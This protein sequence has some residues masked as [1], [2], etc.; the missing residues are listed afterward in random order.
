MT[1]IKHPGQNFDHMNLL[2]EQESVWIEVIN[3]IDQA[4]V[5]LV[6]TQVE[7]EE[8]NEELS[9]ARDFLVN[10]QRH[11]SDL[12]IVTSAEGN[13]LRV[14]KSFERFTNSNLKDLVGQKLEDCFELKDQN[15]LHK[16]LNNNRKNHQDIKLDLLTEGAPL[17]LSINCSPR[18]DTDGQYEGLVLIGR[19]I[20]ELQ[21]AYSDLEKTHKDLL[22]KEEQLVHSEK[23]ASLGRLVA[24]V[25][26][27]MNNPFSFVYANVHI[28]KNYMVHMK[29]YLKRLEVNFSAEQIEDLRKDLPVAKILKDVNSLIE[30]SLEGTA[31][32]QEIIS[33]L[34]EFSSTQTNECLEFDLC[35][36]VKTA[37]SW[38]KGKAD[39]V[40]LDKMPERLTLWAPPGE[41]NQVVVNLLIN[42][43]DEMQDQNQ[44]QLEL[45]AGNSDENIW[46][47][48]KD[49]G[50][51]IDEK[52]RSKIWEPFF[53]T[54]P[55]GKGTGLGLSIS[56]GIIEKLGGR[57]I[58][59]NHSEGAQFT[60]TLPKRIKYE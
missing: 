58:A 24:G 59:E 13:I 35:K 22:K 39:L 23:M 30:G 12:L 10:I 37:L 2:P 33:G 45:S 26:H 54:K 34:K 43:V 57:L 20:G 32:I 4:Y 50:K 16:F 5:E 25:A 41:I 9:K 60:M 6:N 11:M 7:L 49:W 8:S 56:L 15:K 21:R 47:C 46:F 38:V 1:E 29:S 42:A 31:R 19:P 44:A 18:F 3:K 28:L 14:N 17:R 51:G 40:L 48:V 55:V 27:E 36:V 53:T 52:N